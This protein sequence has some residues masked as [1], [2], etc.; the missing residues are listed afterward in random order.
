MSVVCWVDGAMYANSTSTVASDTDTFHVP[1]CL[2]CK[3]SVL[4]FYSLLNQ[5]AFLSSSESFAYSGYRYLVIY[6]I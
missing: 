4:V 5:F 3:Q 6:G 1:I 2:L